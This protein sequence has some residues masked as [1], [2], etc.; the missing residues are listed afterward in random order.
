MFF[1]SPLNKVFINLKNKLLISIQNKYRYNIQQKSVFY[2]TKHSSSFILKNV[3]IIFPIRLI[4]K[5]SFFELYRIR[6]KMY[7]FLKKN[8]YKIHIFVSRKKQILWKKFFL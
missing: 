1:Y 2:K 6:K 7:S 4:Y 5:Y 3:G 8:E